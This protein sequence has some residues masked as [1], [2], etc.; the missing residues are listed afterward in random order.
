MEQ[1]VTPE[2]TG[3]VKK[4]Q[5]KEAGRLSQIFRVVERWVTPMVIFRWEK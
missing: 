3:E 2:K 4:K 5:I 1:D